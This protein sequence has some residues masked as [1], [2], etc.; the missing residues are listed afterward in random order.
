MNDA[1]LLRKALVLAKKILL[2]RMT[3]VPLDL[4]TILLK[5]QNETGFHTDEKRFQIL[6]RM[7]GKGAVMEA[8]MDVLK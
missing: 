7:W 5:N 1:I 4:Q 2:A 8:R 6:T 3:A